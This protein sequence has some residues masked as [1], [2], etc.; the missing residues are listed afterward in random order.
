MLAGRQEFLVDNVAVFVS[1]GI[2]R[3]VIMFGGVFLDVERDDL[4][5]Y[6]AGA[7]DDN[8]LTRLIVRMDEIASF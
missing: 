1:R 6:P 7:A 2:E 5:R 3:G 4:A 8:R